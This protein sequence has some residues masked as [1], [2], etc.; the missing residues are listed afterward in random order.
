MTEGHEEA[1][2]WWVAKVMQGL[3]TMGCGGVEASLNGWLQQSWAMEDR[4]G[5]WLGSGSGGRG[6]AAAAG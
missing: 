1:M 2:Q 4:K 6:A 5:G 3:A